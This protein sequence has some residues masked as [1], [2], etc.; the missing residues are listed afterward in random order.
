[1]TL[2]DFVIVL[3]TLAVATGKTLVDETVVVYFK[4]L[5]DVPLP[6]FQA[7]IG[8]LIQT[9]RFFPAPGVIRA[10]CDKV[11][12]CTG[13]TTFTVPPLALTEDDPR[14]WHACASCQ[15]TGWAS[16]WCPGSVQAAAPIGFTWVSVRPCGSNACARFGTKGYGHEFVERCPCYTQNEVI[17]KRL[18]ARKTYAEGP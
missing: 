3:H 1:M 9:E 12:P 11:A 2:A 10:A 7:A 4:A 13:F 15:D 16:H 18:A 17:R 14:L 8:R 5:A 6:T